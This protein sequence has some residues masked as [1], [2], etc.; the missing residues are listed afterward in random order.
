MTIVQC[1]PGAPRAR[2]KAQ[3]PPELLAAALDLFVRKGFAA[4]RIEDIAAKAGVSKGTLYLYYDSKEHLLGE[5]VARFLSTDFSP[6]ADRIERHAGSAAS[7]I[8]DVLCPWWLE[9]QDKPA[10]SLFKLIVAE[11]QNRPELAS[12]WF[13]HVS[14]PIERIFAAALRKGVDSGEFRPVDVGATA[15][16]MSFPLL[17]LCLHRHSIGACVPGAGHEEGAFVRDHMALVLRDLAAPAPAHQN[18]DSSIAM[19]GAT[20][21]SAVRINPSVSGSSLAK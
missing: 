19:S 9:V 7:L 2:R 11:A 15:R 14:E 4:T 3:R 12:L 10:A 13:R 8:A 5:V 17:M 6:V 20:A 1:D 16:L 21:P 18:R